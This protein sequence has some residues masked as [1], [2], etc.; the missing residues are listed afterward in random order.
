[1]VLSCVH[2][3]ALRNP[4]EMVARQVVEAMREVPLQQREQAEPTRGAAPSYL[5]KEKRCMGSVVTQL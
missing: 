1:M 3:D 2:A 4:E 5:M